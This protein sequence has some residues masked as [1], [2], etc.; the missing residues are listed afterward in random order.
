MEP[1]PGWEGRL[2][3]S[4]LRYCSLLR[5]ASQTSATLDRTA[6][7]AVSTAAV[8]TAAGFMAADSMAADLAGCT[9]GDF[10]MADGTLASLACPMVSAEGIAAT[11]SMARVT[12]A[13]AGGGC[14]VGMDFLFI[15]VVG[16][17]P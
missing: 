11:G 6:E 17:L 2:E 7:A 1:G 3:A 13:M 9:K 16:L 5:S 14:R 10:T 15:S 4:Q 12:D 8:S